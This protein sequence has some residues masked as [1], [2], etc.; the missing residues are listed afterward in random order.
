MRST[1][2]AVCNR[3]DVGTFSVR[4]RAAAIR[5]YL[6]HR[7]GPLGRRRANCPS[8]PAIAERTSDDF[9][10]RVLSL[11]SSLRPRVRLPDD[12]VPVGASEVKLF[13][14]TWPHRTP[15]PPATLPAYGVTFF[16]SDDR[17][18]KRFVDRASCRPASSL[19]RARGA[20]RAALLPDPEAGHWS[21]VIGRCVSTALARSVPFRRH[22]DPAAPFT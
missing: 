10:T 16:H 17:L 21:V 7:N 20:T 11:R 1:F 22:P 8:L 19:D 5:P 6:W 2:A 14:P 9:Y 4:L 18:T 15:R 13:P 3:R 12:P